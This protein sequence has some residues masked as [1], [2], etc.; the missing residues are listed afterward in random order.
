MSDGNRYNCPL[1][2]CIRLCMVFL[3]F[4]KTIR[5]KCSRR[6]ACCLTY[7]I[8]FK[9]LTCFSEAVTLWV[10]WVFFLIEKKTFFI[11][12]WHMFTCGI[13]SHI[14]PSNI[15]KGIIGWTIS[16]RITFLFQF[17][18]RA[19]KCF[20]LAILSTANNCRS[21]VSSW[22]GKI[23]INCQGSKQKN[24]LLSSVLPLVKYRIV[25][26]SKYAW[27]WGVHE[28]VLEEKHYRVL[29]IWSSITTRTICGVSP[30][31]F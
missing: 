6:L 28:D 18:N 5:T 15:L 1:G 30:L 24:C 22:R 10:N 8:L 9:K 12:L 31:Y 4:R 23:S 16:S 27:H 29:L 2:I 14:C 20:S 13:S 7:T 21:S 11:D 3:V 26:V 17:N 19:R 25:W